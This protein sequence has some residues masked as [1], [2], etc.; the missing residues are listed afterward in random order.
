MAAQCAQH[1]IDLAAN[2]P[3]DNERSA[4]HHAYPHQIGGHT[5]IEMPIEVVGD[6]LVLDFLDRVPQ[7]DPAEALVRAREIRRIAEQFGAE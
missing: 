3:I 6:G 2:D 1:A 5:R 4:G 7:P